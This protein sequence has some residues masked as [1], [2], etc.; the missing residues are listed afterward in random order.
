M[1]LETP[2][3]E[4]GLPPAQGLYDPAHEH[5][6]CGI[7][8]VAHLRGARSP[9]VVGKA[10]QLLANLEHRSAVGSDATSD[11]SGMLLQLPR[12]TVALADSARHFVMLDAPEWTWTQV[13]RFFATAGGTAKR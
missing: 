1:P 11:G 13:D 8:F 5:E 6:S 10:L 7:G 4:R 12:T 9:D 3:P 2:E